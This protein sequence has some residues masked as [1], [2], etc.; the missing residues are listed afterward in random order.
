MI[1][2][3]VTCLVAVSVFGAGA[4]DVESEARSRV[5]I[6]NAT[7]G[8]LMLL[9]DVGEKRADRILQYRKNHCFHSIDDLKN[10]KYIGQEI[11]D[12]NRD[13]VVVGSCQETDQAVMGNEAYTGDPR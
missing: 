12:Q 13:R 8:Q 2:L 6:N 3:L 11:V 5:D 9:D 1:K 10:V 4:N 7:K